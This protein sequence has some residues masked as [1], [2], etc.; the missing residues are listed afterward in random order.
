[1]FGSNCLQFIAKMLHMHEK[2]CLCAQQAGVLSTNT[3][4]AV[5]CITGE[6]GVD[7]WDARIWGV[8]FAKHDVLVCTPQIL[9]NLL[10]RAF[11][12]V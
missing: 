9:L 8:E 2:V 3:P 1:M 12:K 4:L 10:R 7:A 5:R 11:L 6:L